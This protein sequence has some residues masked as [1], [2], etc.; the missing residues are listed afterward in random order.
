MYCTHL[1]V[2]QKAQAVKALILISAWNMDSVKRVVFKKVQFWVQ[3]G[4]DTYRFVAFIPNSKKYY[5]SV[6]PFVAL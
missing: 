2:Y 3:V 4:Y 1:Y 6:W 5:P